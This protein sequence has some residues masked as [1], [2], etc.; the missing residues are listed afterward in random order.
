MGGNGGGVIV[1]V[2]GWREAVCGRHGVDCEFV[3]GCGI[4][5]GGR[6]CVLHWVMVQRL[7]G[8]VIGMGVHGPAGPG[9]AE[10]IKDG[11]GSDSSGALG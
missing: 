10:G 7:G 9:L 4:K 5:E 11:L 1:K 3:V 2:G 8:A 6:V